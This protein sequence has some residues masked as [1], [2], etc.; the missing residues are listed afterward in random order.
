MIKRILKISGIVVLALI[1]AFVYE[2]SKK[3]KKPLTPE[4]N[5]ISEVPE[6]D[7][8]LDENLESL[9]VR[10]LPKKLDFYLFKSLHRPNYRLAYNAD[11]LYLYL[12]TEADTLICRDRGYQNGDGFILLLA[13][14]SSGEKFTN[15]FYVYG[16]SSQ[17]VE[18]QKWA[19]KI[20]WYQDNI[21][22]LRRLSDDVKIRYAA[23]DGIISF[24]LL[25]PWYKAYPFHP[26]RDMIIGTNLWL[27]KAF[28]G[29]SIPV[30]SAMFWDFKLPSESE[31]RKYKTLEFEKHDLTD[32][33]SYWMP[34]RNNYFEKDTLNVNFFNPSEKEIPGTVKVKITDEYD[35]QVFFI[36]ESVKFNNKSGISSI[37]FQLPETHPGT[38]NLIL[39]SEN[40]CHLPAQ[41]TILPEI[42]INQLSNDLES[43]KNKI[44]AGDYNTIS[45]YISEMRNKLGNL[46]PEYLYSDMVDE[47]RFLKN[48]VTDYIQERKSLLSIK[49]VHRRAFVSGIDNSLRPYSVRL[50][51]DFDPLKTYPLLVFLHGSGRTDTE[52]DLH[53]YIFQDDFIC[54]APNGRGISNYYGTPESQKDINEAID[55]II[56][57]FRIDTNNIILSGFSMGGYGVYRTYFENPVRYK[58]I[59]VIAGEPKVNLFIRSGKGKY[60]DFLKDKNLKRFKDIP[61]FV[62]HGVNDLNCPYP[63]TRKLIEK[64]ESMDANL[65]KVIY[66]GYGHSVPSGNEFTDRFRE[67]IVFNTYR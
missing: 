53:N 37:E 65:T 46:Q 49:D 17:V 33:Q 54:I 12:E 52:L 5:Y 7:G 16:F 45:F 8:F 18:E 3:Q 32:V 34:E 29:K 10:K 22:E 1:A 48:I 6:I 11:Y 28:K 19:E 15:K 31:G 66:T 57:N 2:V 30:I 26:W 9:P 55:D 20:I 27:L 35:Q 47:I 41:F 62:Y 50:P 40:I 56:K 13:D 38:Y 59:A 64:L 24:E 61:V 25:L 60:P 42:D 21:T 39:E 51:V 43:V 14:G 4:V 63:A 67:W 58:A 36:N 44:S 23:R